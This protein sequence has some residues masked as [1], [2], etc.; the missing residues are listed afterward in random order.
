MKKITKAILMCTF[1]STMTVPV[2]QAH[3]ETKVVAHE[4]ALEAAINV[5][6][7]KQWTVQFNKKINKD[8]DLDKFVYVEDAQYEKVPVEISIN[9][10]RTNVYVTPIHD[11]DAGATY[12][13]V[14]NDQ[15]TSESGKKLKEQ[16][17]KTFTTMAEQNHSAI[18]AKNFETV[19]D[20]N[21]DVWINFGKTD[22][23][24]MYRIVNEE[25]V[26][27]KQGSASTTEEW[28]GMYLPPRY[29]LFISYTS[30]PTLK[31][32]GEETA[33]H[34]D[35]TTQPAI[36]PIVLTKDES[37]KV[38]S[39]NS[40]YTFGEFYIYSD[41][42]G[43][44]PYEYDSYGEEGLAVKQLKA[45]QLTDLKIGL[46]NQLTIS[47]IQNEP[48][49]I[50]NVTHQQDD[51]TI[52]SEKTNDHLND[53][54]LLAPG[55]S[56]EVTIKPEYEEFSPIDLTASAFDE[57]GALQIATY[58]KLE[59]NS[60]YSTANVEKQFYDGE[61]HFS[62]S[63]DKAMYIKNPTSHTIALYDRFKGVAFKKTTVQPIQT[64][65]IQPGE[66]LNFKAA[67]RGIAYMS[68]APS[69][70]NAY[71]ALTYSSAEDGSQRSL[72]TIEEVTD[73]GEHKIYV[74]DDTTVVNLN[75]APLTIYAATRDIKAQEV[76]VEMPMKVTIT[77]NQIIKIS[78]D[79]SAD[80][81]EVV[82][83]SANK[84]PATYKYLSTYR[85]GDM[86][87]AEQHEETFEADTSYWYKMYIDNGKYIQNTSNEN[88]DVYTYD[89][90]VQFTTVKQFPDAPIDQ[91]YTYTLDPG[92]K[93]KVSN[94]NSTMS[95][96]FEV[97]IEEPAYLEDNFKMN[98]YDA[99]NVKLQEA[100]LTRS[101]YN[102]TLGPGQ[103]MVLENISNS[104]SIQLTLSKLFMEISHV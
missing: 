12:K 26:T 19:N 75:D 53:V 91:H 72:S 99:Y 18:F 10:A 55:E 37:L 44:L 35:S 13:L 28:Q 6:I 31:P 73:I 85:N 93:I 25:G 9:N 79:H 59:N 84:R 32:Y 71:R 101:N 11:Y 88:I 39:P 17:V 1:I 42:A 16:V 98:Q 14:I 46:Q 100:D 57:Q 21:D 56:A 45:Q 54:T 83:V 94:S 51:D 36:E 40:E 67:N 22:Q 102:N 3:A 50:F 33:L 87:L 65:V 78:S 4:K 104:N 70:T 90:N 62:T 34:F 80:N 96:F 77:P 38:I 29:K 41:E 43:F 69:P 47:N 63:L 86:T 2:S 89:D 81:N 82:F 23:L 66:A 20:T 27:Y 30:A 68:V 95:N 49:T 76:N 48:L 52:V 15:L 8:V 60:Y 5:P 58:S 7:D 61:Y 24:F 64:Y 103:W 97:A 92:E 74:A